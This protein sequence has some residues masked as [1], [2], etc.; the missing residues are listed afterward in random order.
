MVRTCQEMGSYGHALRRMLD[1]PV[2]EKREREE[3]RKPGGN[4]L[5]MFRYMPIRCGVKDGGLIG[6]DNME[7][8]NS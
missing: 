7:E 3:D 2:P 8:R 6:Q 4:N 1:A 5:V